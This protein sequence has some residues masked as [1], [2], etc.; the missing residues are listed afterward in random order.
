VGVP[1]HQ[2]TAALWTR[3]ILQHEFGVSPKDMEFWMGPERNPA[4]LEH[5]R[6]ARR[7]CGLEF[8]ISRDFLDRVAAVSA[9][10]GRPLEIIPTDWPAAR[11]A[12]M[13]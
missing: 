3:G 8:L 6:R 13:I 10:P 12:R 11:V 9:R 2:Q 5:D 1:E 7:F 4:R